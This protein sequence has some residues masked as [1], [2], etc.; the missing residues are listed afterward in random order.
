M[1][2]TTT[3]A[4]EERAEQNP[5]ESLQ[6]KAHF[7][8]K[9][10]KTT[11][12]GAFVDINIGVPGVVHI[13]QL[14]KD[15]VNRVEDVVQPGQTVD[16]W[17][18]RVF[19]KK[20][21]VELT[22]VKPLDVEWREI[23]PDMVF[24]GTVTRI[25][26]FGAFVEIGAE[27]PGLVHI[28]ELTHRY[29]KSTDEVVKVGDEVTVKVLKVSRRKKQIKLSMKAL[30]EPPAPVEKPVRKPRAERSEAAAA[31]QTEG[32]SQAESAVPTPRPARLAQFDRVPSESKSER[33]KRERRERK[34]KQ[35]EAEIFE[36]VSV[37]EGEVP[38]AFQVAWQA[39]LERAKQ[40]EQDEE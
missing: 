35:Q 4:G 27:R 21:R 38:T 2:E 23:E 3:L 40:R 13:S 31:P 25:E 36:M 9:V 6:R 1:E 26:S 10:I 29:V 8:G 15:P 24:K 19:P 14:Q 17:V 22:M 7:T 30:E 33:P 34:Q 37:S 39:A 20:G 28:S 18:R 11:L 12:A 32:S 16:V 5:L